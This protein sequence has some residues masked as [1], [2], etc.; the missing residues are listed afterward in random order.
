MPQE[1]TRT[2]V[3][4]V[5]QGE[6]RRPDLADVCAACGDSPWR[7]DVPPGCLDALDR[8]YQDEA[9]IYVHSY[10][11]RE[12]RPWAPL[13]TAN[14]VTWGNALE[15]PVAL[16]RTVA[17]AL[18]DLECRAVADALGSGEGTADPYR[19]D[20]RERCAAD[21]IARLSA[22]HYACL[23]PRFAGDNWNWDEELPDKW[24]ILDKAN[25]D[26]AEY[27]RQ[28]RA[29]EDAWFQMGWRVQ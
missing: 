16:R 7:L 24:E 26:F 27:Q 28:R 13:P 17:G 22:F 1:P 29:L 5:R 21:A 25:V 3:G 4:V 18:E 20:L 10:R 15:D 11:I 23:E 8:R 19:H 6:A 12:L 9:A 14:R 2:E